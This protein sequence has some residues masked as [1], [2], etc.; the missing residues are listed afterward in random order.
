MNPV[1]TTILLT[2]F[3]MAAAVLLLVAS[4]VVRLV[5]ALSRIRRSLEDDGYRVRRL[6]ARFFTRGPF[7]EMRALPGTKHGDHLYRV[8]ANDRNGGTCVLWIRVPAAMPWQA[9]HWDV[10]RDDVREHTARGIGA[11][12]FYAMIAGFVTGILMIIRG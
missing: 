7:S 11:P 4:T 12:V 3:A 6:E 8:S 5:R 1:P 10:R 9:L 2:L